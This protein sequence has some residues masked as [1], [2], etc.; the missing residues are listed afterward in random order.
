MP[1]KRRRILALAAVPLLAAVAVG[2]S[3]LGSAEAAPGPAAIAPRPPAS[4]PA[5]SPAQAASRPSTASLP[6]A[7]STA[8]PSSR[9]VSVASPAAGSSAGAQLAAAQLPASAV[10]RWQ[11]VGVPRTRTVVGHD[12][13]ENE[14]VKVH[15]AT[16]W[17]Q[18]AFAGGDG[19]NMA[20]QDTFSLPT[21][22]AARSA[23]QSIVAEMDACQATSRA[24]QTSAGITANA[25]VVTT[26]R[27]A[28]AGS[29]QRTWTGVLGTSA[30]GPQTN[31][32]YAAVAGTHL[33]VLTFSEYPGHGS[34][35][36][37]SGDAQVLAT[38]TGEL[39]K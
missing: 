32:F 8:A 20:V 27:L 16:T 11:P 23:Y 13:G 14:C 35:Y 6:S 3:E 1:I 10:E 39:A 17:T 36:A 24:V 21:T 26:D 31:H 25:A 38:L 19:Q 9:P 4:S 7:S 28:N 5:S 34:A 29:W 12:I 30:S 18:Q 22:A 37:T 2:V 15:G 33:I